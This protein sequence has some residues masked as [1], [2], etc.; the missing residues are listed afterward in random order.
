[1]TP[2]QSQHGFDGRDATAAAGAGRAVVHGHDVQ[3]Y[4]RE[5][6]LIDRV[7]DY[8]AEGVRLGQPIVVIATA[9]HRRGF[10]KRMRLLG[11]DPDELV[12]GRDVLWLDADEVLLAF[13]EGGVVNAELFHATV[14]SLLSRLCAGRPYLVM[15]AYG[16]MVDLLW[17]AGRSESA[18]RLEELWNELARKHRFALLCAYSQ[19]TLQAD[20]DA[21]RIRRMHE[22]HAR[23]L[24]AEQRPLAS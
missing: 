7:G 11:A 15:R 16:E 2:V 21:D 18:L 5:D 9:A 17:R 19:E 13:T 23:V 3:L 4:D 10:A 24:S 1:M 14:G 6:F 8:L 20:A 22:Q 12:E